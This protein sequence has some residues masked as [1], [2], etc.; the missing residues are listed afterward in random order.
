MTP[1]LENTPSIET[2]RL[3]LRAPN[4]RD[5]DAC[6]AFLCSDR[7]RFM[8]GPY[9]RE[10]AW[11]SMGHLIGHWV[12]R[13][14]G[15]FIFC[16][17]GTDKAIGAAGPF[18]PE[19]W[20]EPEIGWSVWDTGAEGKGYAH[21][22]AEAARTHAFLALGWKTAVSYIDPDNTRSIRLAERLGCVRD[23]AAPLP[24]LPD[25]EGTLVYRH[26]AKAENAA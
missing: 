6:A 5:W 11:R 15:M 3:V 9:T 26:P 8:D 24:A 19:G 18:F 4:S 17:K 10:S 16:L 12:L 2:G 22:A 1:C 14:Y 21:E 23:P 13:G 20:P 7:S 25:W